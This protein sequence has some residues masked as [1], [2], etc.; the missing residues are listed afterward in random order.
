[1]AQSSYENAPVRGRLGL[2]AYGHLDSFTMSK[3]AGEP[4]KFG[5]LVCFGAENDQVERPD[6]TGDVTGTSVGFV[7]RNDAKEP[8]VALQDGYDTEDS[9]SVCTRSPGFWVYCETDSAK[10]GAVFVRFTT[11]LS[12]TGESAADMDLGNVRNDDDGGKAVALPG[13]RFE[14]DG[15]G[16]GLRIISFH[17]QGPT[18]GTGATG[19]TGAT[20]PTGAT[21]TT[22]ATGPTGPTGPA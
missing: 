20:G 18:A 7:E 10:G 14:E 13:A 3:S 5:R 21:G 4:V 2:Q 6:A 9:V 22:G 16:A 15:T 8:S 19:A 17:I 11:D 1:M 12:G